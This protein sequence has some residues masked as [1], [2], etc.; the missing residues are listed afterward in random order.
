M[1]YQAYTN[2]TQLLRNATFALQAGRFGA[3]DTLSF[4]S[5]GSATVVAA[6]GLVLLLQ[7]GDRLL[8]CRAWQL[9]DKLAPA[10]R[11]TSSMWTVAGVESARAV[12]V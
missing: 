8:R 1:Q 5:G 12:G 6:N 9:G 7:V 10:L 3:G 4:S 2:F 11:G